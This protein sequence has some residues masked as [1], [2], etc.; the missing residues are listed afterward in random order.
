MD[1]VVKFYHFKKNAAGGKNWDSEKWLSSQSRG[2]NNLF[3][4]KGYKIKDESIRGTQ[5]YK[6]LFKKI[7]INF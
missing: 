6:A 2:Q 5:L 7:K 1:R 3:E 4:G